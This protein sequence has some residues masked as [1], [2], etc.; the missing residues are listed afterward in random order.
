MTKLNDTQTILLSTA[1]QRDSGSVLPLPDTIKAG[2][3]TAKA[4][5]A[6]AAAALIT[7]HETATPDAVH[8]SD[9]DLRFGLFITPAGLTAI[10]VSADEQQDG[11]ASEDHKDHNEA[12]APA[13]PRQTKAATVLALLQRG[14][15]ATL[16]EL[17]AATG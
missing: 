14:G 13:L 10:G 7:E 12:P 17:I 1:S 4:L 15:G 11:G 9:G 5:A 2:V 6:L 16:P 3:R 8:R